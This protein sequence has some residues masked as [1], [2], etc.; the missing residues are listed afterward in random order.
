MFKTMVF[1]LPDTI[2]VASMLCPSGGGGVLSSDAGASMDEKFDEC[3]TVSGGGTTI[4][5][6]A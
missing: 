2:D 1:G 5:F 3:V 6:N 4:F